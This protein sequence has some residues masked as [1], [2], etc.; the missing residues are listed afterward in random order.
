MRP[1]GFR[2][3]RGGPGMRL[4]QPLS[5]GLCC[6]ERRPA[7]PSWGTVCSL[8][9]SLHLHPQEVGVSSRR[10]AHPR[11]TLSAAVG[12]ALSP[13]M[14]L[15]LESVSLVV[16]LALGWE[17]VCACPVRVRWYPQ[18]TGLGKGV[19]EPCFTSHSRSPVSPPLGWARRVTSRMGFP[20]SSLVRV[21][22]QNAQGSSRGLPPTR[23][24]WG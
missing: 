5:P 4:E 17:S 12:Q 1:W 19:N 10:N 21:S 23:L 2:A 6:T 24:P 22:G 7:P 8:L 18:A 15:S 9:H 20:I 3:C 13:W 11:R 14:A 16:A